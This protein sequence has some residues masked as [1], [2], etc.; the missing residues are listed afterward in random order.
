MHTFE[1]KTTPQSTTVCE[2]KL[3][4]FDLFL[5]NVQKDI[6][7]DAVCKTNIF[8]DQM[9]EVNQPIF[10]LWSQTQH[11]YTKKKDESK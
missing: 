3:T 1:K 10:F 8:P 2:Y 11:I 9:Q 6:K 5:L 4:S 7:K